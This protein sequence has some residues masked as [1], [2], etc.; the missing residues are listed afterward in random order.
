MAKGKIRKFTKSDRETV[1]RIL[2]YIR[3]YRGL[4]LLSVLLAALTVVLTLYIPI[5]TGRAVDAI[6]EKGAVDFAR[7]APILRSM[8]LLILLTAAAQWTMNHI[9]NVVT[10]HVVEDIRTRTFNHLQELPVAYLDTHPSGDIVSRV[11][12]DIDQFSQGLLMGFTQLFT[13]VLT[14]LETLGF[15][16]FIEWRVAVL[17][18]L[19]TPLSFL[20]AAVI[21]RK[22]YHLFRQQSEARGALTAYTNEMVQ[23]LKVVKAFSRESASEARF[24]SLNAELAG[25]S[26][27][28]TFLSSIV[29]PSTRFVNAVVYAAVGTAGS[30]LVI[31]GVMSVGELSALLSYANQYTKPFNEIS[32]VVTEL[33]NALASASRVFE[34]LDEPALC[35]DEPDAAA[36]PAAE[37]RVDLNHVFFSYDKTKKLLCDVDVHVRQGET[38]AIVGPTGCGKSTLINLLMRF[39]DPDSG[40]IELDGLDTRR[41]KRESLRDSFGMVLQETWLKAATIRDNIAYGRP[42]ATDEEVIAAARKA[43][44]DSF[45]RKMPKGYRTV[46]GE[47]GGSLSQGQKQLLCIARLMLRL[48]PMLI[49]DEATSSI[50]TRTELHIQHAFDRMMEG[51]TA[52]IVAHRLSTIRNADLILVMKDG[53]IIEKGSHETLLAAGGFY[54]E[55]YNSQFYNSESGE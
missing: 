4:V 43:H 29:N 7:L 16:F 27:R 13:G 19:L 21:A 1:L 51:R 55:L 37:G 2:R 48:P 30:L 5:L 26:R 8:I 14:I 50:D 45:I 53:N 41:M 6:L 42:E 3:S 25:F 40:S 31:G 32:G 18:V 38:V 49:L 9:N 24:S 12:A 34:L 10:Y 36:F 11:I 54:R 23:N 44:C 22:S 17:V 28:A 20:V 52:F 15:L 46:L 47:G 35:P 39:Y 33:Q